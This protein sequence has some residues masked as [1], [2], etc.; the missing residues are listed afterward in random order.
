MVWINFLFL[1]SL[2]Y[3]AEL[4]K[5]LT[6]H[7]IDHLRFITADGRYAYVEKRKGV[8]GLVS[9]FRSTDFL[10]ENSAS[11]FIMTGS[12]DQQRLLIEVIPNAHQENNLMKNNKIL[13]LDWGNTLTKEVGLGINAKLH[14]Q[15]EWI[16][17]YRPEDRTIVVKNVITQKSYDIKLSPRTSPFFR[18]EVE[19]INAETVV[20]TDINEK[21]TAA[22]IQYNLILKKATIVY[23]SPHNAT[24]LELCHAKGYLGVGEFPFD[25]VTRGSS[26]SVIRLAGGINLAGMSNLYKSVEQDIGNMVC[27]EKSIYFVK[28]MQQDKKV[29]SKITEAVKLDLASGKL[30]VKT[31]LQSVSQLL[32]MDGRVLIPLR[33]DYF[34]LEGQS[35]LGTDVLKNIP[36][37]NE[38]E[39]PLDL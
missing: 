13:I 10:S 34:V 14:V 23:K 37:E 27:V 16:T 32:L 38:E 4:P 20:Y 36:L 30:E 15:D 1:V 9:S 22:L 11:G 2:A 24:H 18:P 21:G 28:T 26:I 31:D 7:A 12:L 29:F 3:T 8:L 17:F 19:M 35:N 33:G 25:G 5:F 39:L 6:K